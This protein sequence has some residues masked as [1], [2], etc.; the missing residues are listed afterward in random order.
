ML[1]A[2]DDGPEII[3]TR[4]RLDSDGRA[5]YPADV[6]HL[7]DDLADLGIVA[8]FADPPDRRVYERLKGIGSDLVV[9]FAV[10]LS[11]SGAWQAIAAFVSLKL[12]RR[13]KISANRTTAADGSRSETF[14]YEGPASDAIEALREWDGTIS[15]GDESQA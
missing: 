11:A 9:P 13:V 6:L 15:G 2:C 8:T 4:S 3:L 5:V 7:V 12:D 10:S 1:G 14:L